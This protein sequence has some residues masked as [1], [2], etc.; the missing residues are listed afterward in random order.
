MSLHTFLCRSVPI[1]LYRPCSNFLHRGFISPKNFDGQLA[2]GA[3]C[4]MLHHYLNAKYNIKTKMMHKKLG[5]N[6]HC[7]LISDKTIFDPTYRQF[8]PR[9]K[10]FESFLYVGMLD[11]LETHV[12]RPYW[13][14]A[15][16]SNEKM[17][18]FHVLNDI[19]YAANKGDCF[20]KLYK[21]FS[22]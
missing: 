9:N 3:S 4:Y 18:V 10:W 11:Q 15:V 19:E 14:N 5:S 20:L 22:N 1:L 17:D 13:S 21:E 12:G 8:L 16:E 2:C 6:D 7:Y